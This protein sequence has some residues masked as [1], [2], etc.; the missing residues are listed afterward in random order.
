[1]VGME[2]DSA[3]GGAWLDR[4]QRADEAAAVAGGQAAD[5]RGRADSVVSITVMGE[6]VNMLFDLPDDN[7]EPGKPLKLWE[8]LVPPHLGIPLIPRSELLVGRVL[9]VREFLPSGMF[10][11]TLWR[12]P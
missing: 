1:M 4:E 8:A 5:L 6:V 3:A 9:D 2:H 11:R 12:L 7:A 10:R